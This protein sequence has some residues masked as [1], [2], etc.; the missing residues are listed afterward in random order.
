MYEYF[1][2]VSKDFKILR[3]ILKITRMINE[4]LKLM[5]LLRAGA[6]ADNQQLNSEQ[7]VSLVTM[8]IYEWIILLYYYSLMTEIH[9][10]ISLQII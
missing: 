5:I 6:P 8:C 9:Y 3:K 2:C 1:D 10:I 7:K 4:R